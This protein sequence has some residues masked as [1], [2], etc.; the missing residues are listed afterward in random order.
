MV[1][2][3][4]DVEGVRGSTE[5]HRPGDAAVHVVVTRVAAAHRGARELLTSVGG[6]E[7]VLRR[8]VD[9]ER[10]HDPR[11]IEVD[12]GVVE[13]D[14]VHPVVAWRAHRGHGEPVGALQAGE[15]LGRGQV[16]L[17]VDVEQLELGVADR[18]GEADVVLHRAQH[19]QHGTVDVA[20]DPL[21]RDRDREVVGLGPAE[22]A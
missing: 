3:V 13:A 20:E 6:G 9:V 1:H 10:V 8:V 15:A 19:R 14:V 4:D 7:R 16:V 11:V 17:A 5:R 18:A 21:L 12:L 2:P 22:V